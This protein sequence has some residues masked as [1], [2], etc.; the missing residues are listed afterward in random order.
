MRH[1]LQ[2]G[3][4][5]AF[6]LGSEKG[7]S[8]REIIDKTKE[9]TGRDFRVTEEARRAGDPAV[10]IA[11]SEKIRRVL[12]WQPEHSST[13][14]IIASAWKWHQAHPYGYAK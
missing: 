3:E 7:F 11:S 12:G 6:N 9:V 14:E 10:L 1:L 2:G 8:V 13:E 4:G 5:G